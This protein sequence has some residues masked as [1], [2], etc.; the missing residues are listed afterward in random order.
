MKESIR[1]RLQQVS[2]RHEEIALLL[3]E[4]EVFSVLAQ[5]AGNPG[6]DR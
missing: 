5:L 1:L 3:S 4:P 2:A 6:R